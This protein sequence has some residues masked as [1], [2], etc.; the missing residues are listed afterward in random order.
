MTTNYNITNRPYASKVILLGEYSVIHDGEILAAPISL[1]TAKWKLENPKIERQQGLNTILDY[2]RTKNNQ[3]I[4]ISRFEE[5]IKEGLYL[6]SDIPSGYGL[7]SSGAIT[8]ALYDL[9]AI[10]KSKKHDAA[11]LKKDLIDIE[12]CFHGVSSGIDPLVIYLNKCVHIDQNGIHVINEPLNLSNYFLID[13]GIARKTAPFVKQYLD[14]TKK[15]S[16][17]SEVDKYKSIVSTAIQAQLASDHSTLSRCMASISQWQYEHLD[18]AILNDFRDLWQ[19]T[20]DTDHISIK[21]CGAGGGGYLL[22][23]ALD[24]DQALSQFS[25]YKVMRIG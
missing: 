14:R 1:H 6:K 16:Y 10:E 17:V 7:G 22:G 9:F 23:Y 13:T 2:L 24:I 5:S 3:V 11:L 18:F 4:D 21:L 25:N 20:L 19:S 8:A 15:D 12:S